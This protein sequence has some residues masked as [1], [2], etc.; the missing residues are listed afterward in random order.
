MQYGEAS[1]LLLPS[2]HDAG[3]KIPSP[4][5]IVDLGAE[6]VTTETV[7]HRSKSNAIET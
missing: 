7:F 3:S 4:K 2:F 6:R 5:S 1:A